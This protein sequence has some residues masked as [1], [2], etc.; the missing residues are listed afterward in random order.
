MSED[1]FTDDDDFTDSEGFTDDE[2][3]S[4]T[5]PMEAQSMLASTQPTP[6]E[7]MP[8][9]L[10]QGLHVAQAVTAAD[11]SQTASAVVDSH[12]NVRRYRQA[13]VAH[14]K[15]CA[16][17]APVPQAEHFERLGPQIGIF[18]YRVVVAQ[19][20]SQTCETVI[21]DFKLALQSIK[22]NDPS[23]AKYVT[24]HRHPETE[25]A[26]CF[27]QHNFPERSEQFNA[28]ID[29]YDFS[30]DK[31]NCA[32]SDIYQKLEYVPNG[33][34]MLQHM[35]YCIVLAMVEI[36]AKNATEFL[37]ASG[38]GVLP[39]QEISKEVDAFLEQMRVD[40][41]TY[42]QTS[43]DGRKATGNGIRKGPFGHSMN[44]FNGG[45]PKT[46]EKA[47]EVFVNVCKDINSAL[48]I[49]EN[50]KNSRIRSWL[51]RA[52]AYRNTDEIRE[53]LGL[54][55]GVMDEMYTTEVA[56]MQPAVKRQR[57]Q[58][59][60][61]RKKQR[62]V[63]PTTEPTAE[64]TAEPT[65]EMDQQSAAEST[66]EIDPAVQATVDALVDATVAIVTAM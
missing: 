25:K 45:P 39:G 15:D 1:C 51:K 7:P 19:P 32:T 56:F 4:S 33:T 18:P 58:S 42:V 35:R 36:Y 37:E 2:D 20:V 48:I 12:D 26:K 46:F 63:Q 54:F 44:L 5:H 31:Y 16:Q 22:G 27:F 6:M 13:H 65:D 23:A 59:K 43:E 9:L 52:A 38:A 10:R 47:F 53:A 55:L 50:G 66:D 24:S 3:L 29:S 64:P 41:E 30:A 34:T 21:E 60:K 57:R 17:V 49:F 61:Q 14:S 40:F 62:N 8:L 11:E 28:L